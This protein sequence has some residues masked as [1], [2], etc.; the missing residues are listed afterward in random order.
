LCQRGGILEAQHIEAAPELV[1]QH[2][3]ALANAWRSRACWRWVMRRGKARLAC[4][5]NNA[6]A[7]I[8]PSSTCF[9]DELAAAYSLGETLIAL[10]GA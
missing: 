2:E 8:S 5:G 9:L 6:T 1:A 10:Y 4:H 3:L 7:A